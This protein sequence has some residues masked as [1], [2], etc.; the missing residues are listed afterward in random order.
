VGATGLAFA[1]AA[2]VAAQLTSFSRAAA[3]LAGGALGAAFVVRA[4]GDMASEGGSAPSWLSPLAWPQQTAPFVLDRWWP[5]TLSFA[6]AAAT[7][8]AGFTL[9][10]RRD[11]GASM[12]AVRPGPATAS[13]WL[14]SPLA[15]AVRLQRAGT[16]GWAL[17][18]VT[19]GLVFGAWADAMR[20]SLDD[21][22]E[23]L[24]DV[25]GSQDDVVAG[26]LGLMALFMALTVG[27]YAVLALQ[28]LR[29]EETSGRGEP[30]LATPVSR[31]AWLGSYLAVASAGIVLLLALT[32][33][34]TGIAAAAVTGEARHLWDVTV[35]H[36]AYAPA[37]LL[38]AGL[39]ALLFGLAPRAIG[40]TWALLGYALVVG[41]FGPLMDLPGWAVSLSP[42]EHV[43]RLPL[44]TVRATP[45]ALLT[46][47]AAAAAAAGLAGFRRR[48][49][50]LS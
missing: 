16:T 33:V 31:S 37:V 18:L 50:D 2:A 19:A 48:D 42:F 12:F 17:A 25:T 46:L 34:A 29:S 27:I 30:V 22:P 20:R 28:A 39:A 45:L 14:G 7:S 43:G 32:G 5:L 26:Y 24:L 21:L 38:V 41:L 15:L 23:A 8:V 4:L 13:G 40:L 10:A 49:L 35:A 9:S 47:L 11:L 3:G 1:G 44:T 6:F 36:V